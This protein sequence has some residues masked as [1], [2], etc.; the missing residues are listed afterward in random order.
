MLR[1]R[2]TPAAGAHTDGLSIIALPSELHGIEVVCPCQLGAEATRLSFR[3][4][5]MR[6]GQRQ[7]LRLRLVAEHFHQRWIGAQEP[8][9][10]HADRADPVGGMFHKRAQFR[11]RSTDGGLRLLAPRHVDANPCKIGFAFEIDLYAR[12][13]VWNSPPVFRQNFSFHLA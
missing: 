5:I 3:I 11:F 4:Q 10:L 6:Y 2:Y 12:E 7:N 9:L 1:T 8:V 13:V